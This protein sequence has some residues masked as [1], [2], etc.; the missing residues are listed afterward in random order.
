MK[1]LNKTSIYYLVFALPV[2][3]VCSGLLYYFISKQIIDGLD[4]S[5]SKKKTVIEHKLKSG[6]SPDF[7]KDDEIT[8]KLLGENTG[9]FNYH[10]SDT[11]LYDSMEAEMI[12]F[13]TYRTIVNDGNNNYEL[14]IN[15]SYIETDDLIASILYPVIFLFIALLAGFFLI[16]WFISRKLWLPFYKTLKQL[17][18][19]KI[20]ETQIEFDSSAIKEFS[21]LNLVLTS[22][23]E[24]IHNDF[25][26]QKQFIENA[27]HEI[28]TPLAVI[29]NKIELLIQSKKISEAD[30]QI[31][32][33]VYNASNKLSSLNKALL[34]LSKIENN[35]FKEVE[36]IRF[37]QLIEQILDRF[38]DIISL[39]NIHLSKR[40][41]G[42][43][44]HKMN[45]VL[46][47]I[48]ISNLIQNSI[49]HNITNG[50]ITIQL[51]EKSIIISN[52]GSTSVGNTTELFERFKKSETST[53]SIG[54]GLAI[55]KEICDNY[56][57]EINYTCINTIHTVQL[58][59]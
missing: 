9:D 51:L 23:T 19:Y 25:I 59:F 12:P 57:I 2:F 1:L 52:T 11:L 46:A 35:Q 8:F 4:E 49:R 6:I 55:V 30:M 16:N 5:L 17:D 32:Q 43:I 10:I 18:H 33:S 50:T 39:K 15:K 47:D 37:N 48:L 54:L 13:R 58:N 26:C 7:L 40:L 56:T 42:K 20:D 29:K 21:E 3:V 14:S 34:L 38:T 45:P 36:E 27:S 31:I 53:E 24:K 22:M 44:I 28:Q 41:D